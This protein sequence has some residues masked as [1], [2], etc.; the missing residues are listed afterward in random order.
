METVVGLRGGK[1]DIAVQERTKAVVAVIIGNGFEWFDFISYGFFSVIIAKIFFPTSDDNLS[2]LLSVSTI[3]VGFFMRPVGGIVLGG[4]ADKI[5][6]RATLVM[7]ITLMTIGTALI[8]F[9]PTYKDAGILAPLMIVCARLLQGFSAGGEMGGA[10]GF[11]RDH[12]PVERLGYYTSW[13]QAS[14]GFAIILAS[15][16]AVVLVKYLSA[17]QVESWGWRIPFLIG[18]CLGPL[19]IYIRNQVHESTEEASRIRERTPVFEIVRRWKSET[20]IGFGLVIFW[21]VCSYVLL[22]YIPTY[23]TKV[24]HL[25]ASTGF[26]AVLVG[27]S[28]VLFVTPIF[29]HLSDRYGRRRFLMGALVIA[30]V[31]AYPMFR[32]LN[33]NPGLHSLLLFQIIFGLVIASYEG[34]ILAALSDTFPRQI[35]STGISISYNLAV[36]TFGGFSAAILTWAIAAAQNN[37]APAFYVMGTAALSFIA[38]A[39]WSPQKTSVVPV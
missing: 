16:L 22:F 30:V 32:L 34:P 20:L 9:A 18:L 23:A 26:I 31:A 13:I 38:A 21:T 11:L 7:T 36:I 37:L 14:I 28:I 19:G 24:L 10:T 12:V 8:A 35:V 27:A 25:P 2:L 15:V 17:E 33:V 6:R 5:G 3:G 1:R 29:G 39:C 4:M